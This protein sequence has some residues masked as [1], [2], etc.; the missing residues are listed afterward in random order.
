MWYTMATTLQLHY[1]VDERS[2]VLDNRGECI[3]LQCRKALVME[4]RAQYT[5]YINYASNKPEAVVISP[6]Q[7]QA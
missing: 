1:T 2:T 3:G 7:V 4:T 5:P 6:Y